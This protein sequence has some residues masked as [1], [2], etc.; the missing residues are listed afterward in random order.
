METHR[1]VSNYNYL[2]LGWREENIGRK[3]K[4]MGGKPLSTSKSRASSS[5]LFSGCSYSFFR[6]RIYLVL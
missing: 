4:K 3:D 5:L 6:E 2:F 1:H